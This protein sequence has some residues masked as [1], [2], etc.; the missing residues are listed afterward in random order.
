M[1]CRA[2]PN[3]KNLKFALADNNLS[4]LT[5]FDDATQVRCALRIMSFVWM[6]A[7]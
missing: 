6:I 5:L 2:R 4:G 3:F 7:R 1:C